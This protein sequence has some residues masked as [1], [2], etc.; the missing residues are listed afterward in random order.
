MY[1]SSINFPNMFDISGNKVAVKSDQASVSSRVR[2]LIL[3]E[4]TS[5]YNKPEFGVGLKRH[6]FQYNTENEKAVIRDRIVNQLRLNEPCAIADETKFADGL[7]FTGNGE[8]EISMLDKTEK[9]KMT[10]SVACNFGG[11]ADVTIE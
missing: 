10:C 8:S 9:L 1:T 2:L 4:P 3:S 11:T 5:L 6:M 7:M